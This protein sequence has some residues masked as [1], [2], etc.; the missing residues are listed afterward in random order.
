[1]DDVIE[2]DNDFFVGV[3]GDDLAV[4]LPIHGRV[5]KDRALRLAAWIVAV[6]DTDD[7]F[8]AV[9]KAVQST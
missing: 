5:P 2:T 8:P 6:M 1:M 7:E 9:L 4:L 3:Q